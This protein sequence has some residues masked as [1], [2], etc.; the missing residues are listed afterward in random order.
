MFKKI[1]RSLRFSEKRNA[2][3]TLILFS[4]IN[5]LKESTRYLNNITFKKSKNDLIKD[6]KAYL[7][8]NNSN[9]YRK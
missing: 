2:K 9:N 5:I 8:R 1:S 4:V 7:T 6:K 3:I